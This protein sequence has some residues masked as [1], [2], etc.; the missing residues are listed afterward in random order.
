[1]K[2]QVKNL[3]LKALLI[4]IRGIIVFPLIVALIY[5]A[6]VTQNPEAE[7]SHIQYVAIITTLCWILVLWTVVKFKL[8]HYL[9]S[10]LVITAFLQMYFFNIHIKR[11]HYLDNCLDKGYVWDY[12][13]H[14]CRTDCLTWNTI[15]KCVPL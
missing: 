4:G 10:A 12:D 14:I 9:F 11:A 6:F 1:M 2:E 13:Q 8:K 7:M 15:Q 5:E 3:C